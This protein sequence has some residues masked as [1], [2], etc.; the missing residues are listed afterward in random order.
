MKKILF[1]L[2]FVCISLITPQT[3]AMQGAANRTAG[4][5][6]KHW[7]KRGFSGFM[8]TLHWT[9]AAGPS[10]AFGIQ[11]ARTLYDEEKMVQY[12]DNANE[13]VT[14]FIEAEMQKLSPNY[15]LHKVKINDTFS[16]GNN[17]SS[18]NMAA[19]GKH[20][21]LITSSTA[22]EITQ[23]LEKNDTKIID[24]W[25]AI[26]QRENKRIQNNNITKRMVIDFITPFATHGSL[27]IFRN[28]LPFAKSFGREQLLKLPAGLIK[29]DINNAIRS[30]FYRHQETSMDNGI[31][32][33]IKY[34][35]GFKNFLIKSEH[36]TSL[37]NIFAH[38]SEEQYQLLYKY[39]LKHLLTHPPTEE[40]IENIDTRIAELKQQEWEKY[41]KNIGNNSFSK[42]I[43][44]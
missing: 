16:L 11:K 3:N 36:E 39:Y 20:H 22:N 12:Y 30:T 40:R 10:F 15:Q 19:F 29:H 42:Q 24:K 43:K 32:N 25:R 2:F 38:L 41:A 44:I 27:K 23:A 34:L 17:R 26:I 1:A 37:R 6:A 9:L 5:F 33:K 14:E 8:T 13:Q 31:K 35:E 18:H 4:Q 7:A 21:I 28:C